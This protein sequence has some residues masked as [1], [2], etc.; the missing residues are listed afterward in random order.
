MRDFRFAVQIL[1]SGES[2]LKRIK[3]AL[4]I[5]DGSVFDPS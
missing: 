2:R 4:E 3:A 5:C 1:S